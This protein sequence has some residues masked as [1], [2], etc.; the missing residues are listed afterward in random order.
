MAGPVI[1]PEEAC[2]RD[3][4]YALVAVAFGQAVEAD[5]VERLRDAD[6]LSVSVVADVSGVVC[7]HAC[8]SPMAAC[9][10]SG[11]SGVFALAPVSVSPE[12]QGQGLGTLITQAAIDLTRTR[13]A[14]CLTVLGDPAFYGRFGFR[15]AADVGLQ[16]EA[17]DFGEAFMALALGA[18]DL[19]T[20]TYRWHAAFE[21]LLE[22]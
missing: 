6:A 14:A 19:P 20:G 5:L 8:V 12:T 13:G 22:G 21:P 16:A 17:G 18:E 7:A 1:R 10:A 2:D 9:G 15:S 4:I 11:A 3:A